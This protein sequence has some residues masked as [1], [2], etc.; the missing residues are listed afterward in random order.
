MC[1]HIHAHVQA[2]AHTHAHLTYVKK[3]ASLLLSFEDQL[4]HMQK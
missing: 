4:I 2:H 1:T 3:I